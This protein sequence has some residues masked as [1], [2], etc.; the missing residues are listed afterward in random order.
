MNERLVTAFLESCNHLS[1]N[2]RSAYKNDLVSLLEFCKERGLDCRDMFPRNI[3]E[4][5]AQRHRKGINGRTLARSLSSLRCFYKY[6]INAGEAKTNPAQQ[7]RAPKYPRRLPAVLTV[8]DCMLLLD[9][10][11]KDRR[12]V[13]DK[14]I[15]ELLYGSGLR[16]AEIAGLNIDDVDLV[17]QMARIKG[18]GNKERLVPIGSYS[19]SALSE[20]LKIRGDIKDQ[21]ALFVSCH[22]WRGRR[23]TVRAYQWLVRYW[24]N[25]QLGINI[26]P[27]ILRHSFA[28]HMLESCGD[29]RAVQEF[30]GHSSIS[31]TAIYTHLNFHHLVREYEQAHPRARRQVNN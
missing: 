8:D 16:V 18:K 3:Q 2:T 17:D 28:S 10:R 12:T 30:L 15:L 20:W 9:F 13:R 5:I 14:A 26:S 6:L 29:L 31:T 21:P 7:I 19:K 22:S 1:Q 23:L 27:H 11:G 24:S 4:L 25:K